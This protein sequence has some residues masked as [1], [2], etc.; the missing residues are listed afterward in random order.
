MCLRAHARSL[1]RR[2]LALLASPRDERLALEQDLECAAI[3]APAAARTAGRS[4]ERQLA[5]ADLELVRVFAVVL[6]QL[7]VYGNMPQQSE[8]REL[9]PLRIDTMH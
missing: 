4:V 5:I 8:R 3:Q 7:D 9:T 1:T 6:E 2:F